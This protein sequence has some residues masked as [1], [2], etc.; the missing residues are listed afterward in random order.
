MASKQKQQEPKDSSDMPN[1]ISNVLKEKNRHCRI[2]QAIKCALRMKVK[3]T[4]QDRHTNTSE[5][6]I[7]RATVKE[8][9]KGYSSETRKMNADG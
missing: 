2:Q 8:N 4:L 5:T 6:V 1:A 3:Y 7:N 9:T